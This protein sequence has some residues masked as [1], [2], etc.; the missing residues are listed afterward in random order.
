MPIASAGGHDAQHLARAR[1]SQRWMAR[2][3]VADT[4]EFVVDRRQQCPLQR[5]EWQRHLHVVQPTR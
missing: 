4:D 5:A 3:A 1:S 2:L